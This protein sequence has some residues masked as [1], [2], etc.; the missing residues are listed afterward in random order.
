MNIADKLIGAMNTEEHSLRETGV[1]GNQKHPE[2]YNI[3]G[4]KLLAPRDHDGSK[5]VVPTKRD[6]PFSV[7]HRKTEGLNLNFIER[8]KQRDSD[9]KN[10]LE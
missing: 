6:K 7:T 3:V 10:K 9:L 5:F 8:E 2:K 1:F 4:G